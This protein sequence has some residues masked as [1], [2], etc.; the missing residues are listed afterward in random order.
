MAVARFDGRTWSAPTRPPSSR[1]RCTP[2]PTPCTTAARAS[3][4]SRPTASPTA[5]CAA[6]RAD[7]HVA[8][9]RQS[10]ARLCLPVPPAD[11]RRRARSSSPS[12]PTPT[13]TPASPGA[14]YLRPTLLGTDVTIGAAASP[15]ATAM[16]YVLACPVGEYLPPRP[17]HRRR[18]DGDAA[19]DA[20]VRRRQDGR[21]LRDGAGADHG[22]PRALATPTRCCSRPA[23]S[24]RRPARPTCCCSTASDILTPAL[25]DAYLHGVTRDS[26]L[27]LAASLGWRRRRSAR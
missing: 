1:S 17:P 5:R 11:A 27:R 8:R 7:A 15:S 25:T 20:A 16:L 9:L 13:L 18:R 2:A 4:A 26:L 19:H 22:G 14:L 24:C 23:A 3:R 10:A 6:F 12:P 21:Q